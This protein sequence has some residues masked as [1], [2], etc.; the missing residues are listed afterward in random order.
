MGADR[1]SAPAIDTRG[2]LARL[3]GSDLR[4]RITESKRTF[5]SRSVEAGGEAQWTAISA[6][7][8]LR[9]P[10][11]GL[12]WKMATAQ[13]RTTGSSTRRVL[14]SNAV[15]NMVSSLHP[16]SKTEAAAALAAIKASVLDPA[17]AERIVGVD[18]AF[19]A[20]AG[21]LRVVFKSE[22]DS[23]VITSIVAHG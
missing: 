17:R 8:I 10:R 12:G 20:R 7:L 14:V 9:L 2:G 13:R 16:S 15:A 21:D 4:I 11:S 18:N 3:K 23:V 19:V 5:A 22:G 1:A 6:T